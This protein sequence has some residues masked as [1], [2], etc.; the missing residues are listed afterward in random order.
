MAR[1]G[2]DI[3]IVYLPEEQQDAEE[4]KAAVEREQRSCLLLPGDLMANETCRKAVEAHVNQYILSPLQDDPSRT[5]DTMPSDTAR[6]TSSS[7]TPVSRSCAPTLP[8]STSIPSRAH[9]GVTSSPCSPSPS[10][11]CHTWRRDPRA[12]L[13]PPPGPWPPTGRSIDASGE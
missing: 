2:A 5:S 10:T 13:D 6:S 7:T 1:E 8:T 11:L 12:Y 9:F 3:S 4:T